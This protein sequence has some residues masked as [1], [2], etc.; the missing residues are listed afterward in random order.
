MHR[1]N[2]VGPDRRHGLFTDGLFTDW[3]S[4]NPITAAVAVIQR[5]AARHIANPVGFVLLGLMWLSLATYLLTLTG[6][7]RSI[8]ASL[9]GW[10]SAVPAVLCVLVCWFAVK[11]AGHSR[12]EIALAAVAVSST[13]FADTVYSL[14][15]NGASAISSPLVANVGYLLF[16]VFLLA[17]LSVLVRRRLHGLGWPV[18]LDTVVVSLG[19]AAVLA[20]VLEPVLSFAVSAAGAPASVDTV[21]GLLFPVGDLLLVAAI[22]AII[23][24][25]SRQAGRRWILLALGVLIFAAADVVYALGLPT[26]EYMVGSVLDAGWAI[27]LAVITLWVHGFAHDTP[28]PHNLNSA[29]WTVLTPVAATIAGLSVLLLG[30]QTALSPLPLIL[31]GL[32]LV[33]ATIPVAYRQQIAHRLARTDDL[34]GLLNRRAFRADAMDRLVA[35]RPHALLMLDLDRF[36]EL[37]DSLG[38]EAGDHL[39]NAVGAQ[40]ASQLRAGDLVGRLG[41]DEFGILLTDADRERAIAV[42]ERLR[43]AVA[44]P[45]LLQGITLQTNV[46]I[47]IALHPEQGRDLSQLLRKAD[48]AMY[49]SKAS[50]QGPHVY[51]AADN[52]HGAERLR[53]LQELRLALHEGQLEVYY[54]PKVDLATDTVIGAEALVRWNHPARGVLGPGEFLGLA[55][56]SGLMDELTRIVMG[57]AL[58]HAARWQHR[59]HPLTVSVNLAPGSLADDHLA[60]WIGDLLA[61]RSLPSELLMLEITE[62]FLIADRPRAQAILGRLRQRGI[63]ISIDDF[64]TGYSS[65]AYLRDLPIDEIKLDQSFVMPMMEC[66]RTAAL[67]AAAVGLIHSLEVPMVAEGIENAEALAELTRLGCDVGQGY[68]FSR[69]LPA[70]QFD[71]WLLER[72]AAADAV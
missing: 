7:G 29:W 40:I 4:A 5:G 20:V 59:G 60:S 17:A 10:L 50:N 71:R 25:E 6:P 66:P 2:R 64:G 58:D 39:L 32:S 18:L 55:E 11:R 52:Q 68:F 51:V 57:Q 42:A 27:G 65:L 14:S 43:Q 30:T 35:D 46:S 37:N 22:A 62:E 26:G 69:P 23:T 45:L 33:V 47:G 21:I 24:S 15:L 38:H 70:A 9:T 28:K 53:T 1:N 61:A 8:T 31:A 67:V 49:R 48:T 12:P 19:A 41:G 34:T 44:E 3:S 36:K 16:Y 54:Q 72:R 13:V 56:E 63:R